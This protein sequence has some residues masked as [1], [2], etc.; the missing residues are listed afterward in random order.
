MQSEQ[1]FNLAVEQYL[2][3]VYR[4]ALNWFG[5]VHDAEDAAQEV[6][7]RLWKNTS[8]FEG[9]A[10]LRHWLVRV[11]INVCKDLSRAP[12]RLHSVPLAQAPPQ[13][14]AD[15]PEAQAVVEEILRLP[16]KYRVPLYLYHYEGYSVREIS[17]LL[18]ANPSTIR[19]RLS[20]AR[21]LLKHQLEE[22]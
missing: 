17:A 22:G 14:C 4:I 21:E 8:G 5:S 20:R 16:K 1:E 2:N 3:M 10:H 9:D 18:K 12:W 6:M 15:E 7:L 13:P 19:T 11:T